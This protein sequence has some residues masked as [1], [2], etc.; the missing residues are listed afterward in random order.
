MLRLA[1]ITLASIILAACQATAPQQKT[2]ADDPSLPCFQSI[3]HNPNVQVLKPKIGSFLN[4][5][6][7]TLDMRAESS[8]PTAEEK[9]AI[10]A[11][12]E[13]RN[14]CRSIGVDFRNKYAPPLYT[15]NLDNALSKF[16]VNLSKLYAGQMNYGQFVNERIMLANEARVKQAQ[17]REQDQQARAA[18]QAQASAEMSNALMLLQLSQPRPA[19][20]AP[21]VSCQSRNV[22]GT[23][24]TDCR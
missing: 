24:Y 6:A 11:W 17:A 19:P 16:M 5:E 2:A 15:A 18:Q 23:V 8:T 4:P 21:Q 7:A 13:L 3:E 12:A 22:G 14:T 20:V 9:T 10:R 1:T